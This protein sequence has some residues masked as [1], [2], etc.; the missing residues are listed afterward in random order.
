MSTKFAQIS[1]SRELRFKDIY[2]EIEID[3]VL[4]PTFII[5]SRVFVWGPV[6]VISA[7]VGPGIKSYLHT[8]HVA[9]QP[10]DVEVEAVLRL[11]S[12]G[13]PEPG[14]VGPV[15]TGHPA[16]TLRHVV[17]ARGPLLGARRPVADRLEDPG[18]RGVGCGR[19]EPGSQEV[20]SE[21]KYI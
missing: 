16:Q 13:V 21:Y 2:S 3:R 11:V 7:V 6:T 4:E 14:E 5:L 12:D 10:E 17:Q 20:I 18:P 8:T 15:L 1:K 19:S 9:P